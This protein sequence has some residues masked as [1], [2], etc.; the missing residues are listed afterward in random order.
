[1]PGAHPL[2][3]YIQGGDALAGGAMM[4]MDAEKREKVATGMFVGFLTVGI[5]T[6]IGMQVATYIKLHQKEKSA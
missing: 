4:S 3:E 6:I 2:D 5:L 1:M